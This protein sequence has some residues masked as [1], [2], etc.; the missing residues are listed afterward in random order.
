MNSQVLSL[1]AGVQSTTLYIMAARGEITP[2]PD[3]AI[4]ADTQDEPPHVYEHLDW[5]E[6]TFGD[7]LPIRRVSKGSLSGHIT[8]Q[9]KVGRHRFASIPFHMVSPD[10]DKSISRRQC[11]REYKIEPINSLTWQLYKRAPITTWIG[12]SLD[13][14]TRMKPS[15]IKRVAHRYPLIE[16]R[17]TRHS[18]EMWLRAHGYP[19]PKKSACY[20]C[21]FHSNQEWRNIK[22]DPELWAKAVAFDKAV[23]Q[24][25]G[26]RG[27]SFLH[28]SGLPLAQVDLSTQQDKGQLNMFDVECEG[29]CGV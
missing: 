10:G 28:R 19:I 18:C 17:M 15:R 4:F 27:E 16:L 9:I 11:T 8:Q 1:G 14:A 12:I 25:P 7:V 22:A 6:R 29:M 21:P 23:R 24:I 13:E 2:M 26:M 3:L 5:L 20:Y